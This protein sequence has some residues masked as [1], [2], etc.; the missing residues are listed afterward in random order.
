[1][2]VMMKL[3]VKAIIR[4]EQGRFLLLMHRAPRAWFFLPGGRVH[5]TSADG[6]SNGEP[7]HV[8]ATTARA[9]AATIAG[10]SQPMVGR[11]SR[12]RAI[13]RRLNQELVAYGLI[14]REL[15]KTKMK[16][17]RKTPPL[18]HQEMDSR[19]QLAIYFYVLVVMSLARQVM[20]RIEQE[21]AKSPMA[22]F[23]TTTEIKAGQTEDGLPISPNL[24]KVLVEA[25]IIKN[26]TP[27]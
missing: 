1:M 10:F 26:G 25:G 23:V 14:D 2:S 8:E 6:N 24:Y 27:A 12:D 4:D 20:R 11:E 9:M 5:Y 21:A 15:H 22:R 13:R 19:G 7:V 18:P 16:I 17:Q 3:M